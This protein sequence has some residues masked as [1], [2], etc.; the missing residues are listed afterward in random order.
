MASES[1]IRAKKWIC[2][3][4]GIFC[5]APVRK[6]LCASWWSDTRLD[7]GSGKLNLRENLAHHFSHLARHR[8]RGGQA[9]RLHADKVNHLRH[10]GVAF[11]HKVGHAVLIWGHEFW[12]QAG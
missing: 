5:C 9:W 1:T 6:N 2:V 7:A 8:R 10:S 12:P 3:K 11:D 4:A